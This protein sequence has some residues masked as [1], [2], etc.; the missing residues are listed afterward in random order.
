LQGW[1]SDFAAEQW[2][3]RK[4]AKNIFFLSGKNYY[5][6]PWLLPSVHALFFLH[7][8]ICL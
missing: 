4:W 5:Q 3:I 2:Q 8:H 6:Y 7:I 1:P